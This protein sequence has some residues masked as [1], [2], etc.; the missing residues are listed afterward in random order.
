MAQGWLFAKAM[1]LPELIEFCRRNVQEA[2]GVSTGSARGAGMA[3]L[4]SPGSVLP[5][6]RHGGSSFP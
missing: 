6:L 5:T 2:T 1:K 3:A 4:L